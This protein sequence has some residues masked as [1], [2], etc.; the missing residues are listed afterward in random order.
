[1][2]D[3]KEQKG[4][5]ESKE[6]GKIKIITS[7]VERVDLPQPLVP[8]RRTVIDSFRSRILRQDERI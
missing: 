5:Q 8:Q 6:V 4:I 2:E 1:M 3:E 7:N